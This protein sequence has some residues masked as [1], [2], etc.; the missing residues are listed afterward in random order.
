M[1]T[2]AASSQTTAKVLRATAGQ[3]RLEL[4]GGR[5]VTK[6]VTVPI[7][8]RESIVGTSVPVVVTGTGDKARVDLAE[9]WLDA[10]AAPAAKKPAAK[11]RARSGGSDEA[12]AEAPAEKKPAT[13]RRRSGGAEAAAEP[14]AAKPARRPRAK[15]ASPE[16]APVATA[17]DDAP[18]EE[19]KK[20]TRS[21]GAK[22][23]AATDAPA[24]EAVEAPVEAATPGES[25]SIAEEPKPKRSRSRSR[26][27]RGRKPAADAP[28]AATAESPGKADIPVIE[29]AADE[30]PAIAPAP[31]T[32]APAAVAA[33][34]PEV[35]RTRI[36]AAVDLVRA[37]RAA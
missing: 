33:L 8:V 30:A 24:V 22:A 28:E 6:R 9:N 31:E 16:E 27:G 12:A 1:A 25:P 2:D 32:V 13:R 4:D 5:E 11:R 23:A 36:A 35:L 3:V 10:P 37:A 15:K 19:P 26:G 34:D 20:R 18:A 14:E 29:T 17:A 21:R 7:S